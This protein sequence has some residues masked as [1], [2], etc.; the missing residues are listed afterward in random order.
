MTQSEVT[1]SAGQELTFSDGKKIEADFIL[2]LQK[3]SSFLSRDA[4]EIIFG[5]AKSFALEAFTQEDVDKMKL[6][7]KTFPGSYFVFATLKE[8]L[9]K[10]EIGRIKEFVEWGRRYDNNRN[11][12]RASVIILTGVE[13][14]TDFFLLKTWEE[15]GSEY[16]ELLGDTYIAMNRMNLR[17]LAEF[18][19][20][21]YLEMPT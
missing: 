17:Y 20:K 12:V 1:W 6:L 11:Q 10:D 7:A 15:K 13:L 14:F 18:T 16:K 5:E 8:T 19:Q 21:I 3:K 4:S 9:S 2:W